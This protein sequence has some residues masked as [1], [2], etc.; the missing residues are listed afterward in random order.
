MTKPVCVRCHEE[1]ASHFVENDL[2]SERWAV[3]GICLNT[4]DLEFSE[5]LGK[6]WMDENLR[7]REIPK[8]YDLFD[9]KDV[10]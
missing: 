1:F 5:S 7:I 2:T 4:I 3:C 8:A 10:E 9:T 6:S